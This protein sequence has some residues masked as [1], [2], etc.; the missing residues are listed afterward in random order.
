MTPA[1]LR[2]SRSL[3]HG[4]RF[5]GLTRLLEASRASD[6]QW[7]RH[8]SDIQT[9]LAPSLRSART[10]TMQNLEEP[11]APTAARK[12]KRAFGS[13]LSLP[14]VPTSNRAIQPMAPFLLRGHCLLAT[15]PAHG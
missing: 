1:L 15:D 7:I 6:T 3:C 8:R 2:L 11:L 14:W 4:T 10:S 13:C 12:G 5:L 9:M